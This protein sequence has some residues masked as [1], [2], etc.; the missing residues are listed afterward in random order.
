M[1]GSLEVGDIVR[2]HRS[3][4]Q[5]RYPQAKTP[6]QARVL[7]AIEQCRTRALGGH[8][9][10]C[11]DCGRER[12]AYNSCKNRHCPKCQNGARQRWLKARMAELLPVPY[13]HVVFTLPR[14]VAEVALQNRRVVYGILFRAASRALLRLG[15]DPRLLGGEMGVLAVLH[16]WGQSLTHHPHLH[17][18][19]PAGGLDSEQRWKKCRSQKILLPV[20]VLSRLFRGIFLSLKKKKKNTNK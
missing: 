16:T 9:A 8:I 18:I 2:R 15:R 14:C 3:E 19:V 7:D 6:D 20:R 17:C 4:Y 1:K 13:Y 5:L 12:N 11:G 10:Q